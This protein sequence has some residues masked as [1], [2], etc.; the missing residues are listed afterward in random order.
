MDSETPSNSMT[1]VSGLGSVIMVRFGSGP[2][3]D[4]HVTHSTFN[5]QHDAGLDSW[6]ELEK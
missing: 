2:L 4:D 5:V 6:E 3:S 1:A